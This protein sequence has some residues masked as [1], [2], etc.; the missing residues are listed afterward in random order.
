VTS[1]L[2]L[3]QRTELGRLLD[4]AARAEQA[5]LC[6]YLFA[7]F[8]MKRTHDEG[9]VTYEQLEFM[10]R[11]ESTI[12]RIARQEMEHLGLVF[13]LQTA[14]GKEGSFQMPAF[15]FQEVV[16]GITLR[17][18]LD[19][20]SEVTLISFALV[21]MPMHLS[22]QSPH[23]AFLKARVPGFE[24]GK[25]DGLARLYEK[26]REHIL[27][28]PEDVLFIGLPA[29]QFDTHDVFPGAIRGLDLTKAPAYNMQ[30][31]KVGDRKSA[32]AVVDQITTEGEGRHDEGGAGSHFASFMTILTELAA[33]RATD[34]GFEPARPVLSNPSLQADDT[35]APDAASPVVTDPFA[36]DALALFET[37][38]ETM[39]LGL[40]R[41]FASPEHDK[42][43]RSALQQAVFFP[44][45][46]TII[47]PLGE[48]LT[49]LPA[50][51]P[52][53]P[54][55]RAG[56]S[57]HA[58]E[59]IQ[60][61]PHKTPASRVLLLRY[62]AM[63][64]MARELQEKA[65]LLPESLPEPLIRERLSFLY[66]QIYRSRLNLQVNYAEAAR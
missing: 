28:I 65:S 36:R 13:N 40:G 53:E 25:V 33:F 27:A 32:L 64:T 56:A 39:L 5:L 35:D 7:A 34:P 44:M 4:L 42:R 18:S 63:E 55:L 47:R 20:F 58:P 8:S 49:M 16:D 30:I 45:M 66:Q 22:P 57:F 46:T 26:I 31:E 17:F 54:T 60:L 61:S 38:Y 14:I 12:L 43:E 21:E 50:G 3:A 11:W 15:P 9:A 48:V 10:R 19:R 59:S 24:V 52:G 2:H 41:Y 51:V 6:R 37:S 23:Y 62:Q 29:V 1:N